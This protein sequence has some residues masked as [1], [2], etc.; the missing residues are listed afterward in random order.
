[1]AG[2]YSVSQVNAYIRNMFLQDFMLRRITVSGE[3]SNCKYHPSGHIYFTL[4][5]EQGTLSAVMF[6]SRRRNLTF[7]LENGQKVEASGSIQ[8][9]EAQGKYQLY[10]DVIRQA[11]VGDLYARFE[12]L[13]EKLEEMGMFAPE[14]KKPIPRFV[15]TVGIVTASTGAAIRDIINIATRRNPYVQL[16]LCPALVQGEG[17][18][19]SI[20]HAIR[21]L[22]AMGLDCIIAGRG[23]GSIE[24]LWA[25]N[26]EEVAQAIFHCQTPIISAVGH[27]TDFTIA[28]FVAD[29]RAPT[30]S[31]AAELAV[32]EA[33]RFFREL[34][35]KA[36]RLS[37]DMAGILW[38]RRSE[39]EQNRLK[40]MAYSPKNR[41]NVLRSEAAMREKRLDSAMI[42]IL[43]AK[44]HALALSA[45]RLDAM[46]PLAHFRGGYAFAARA[47]GK[48]IHSV[49]EVEAGSMV[50]VF[51]EDGSFRSR[52]EEINER[53]R[54]GEP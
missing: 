46:S 15:R 25:F 49:S 19:A 12:A 32:F 20:A 53:S 51:L 27:E 28:D 22:D 21:R 23:G 14:Y 7:Q 38:D 40:L 34:S 8:I 24:D 39:V 6:Q 4:K 13:K 44:K 41:L 11:G 18:A 29:L 35:E 31:A 50:D 9:Y 43:E 16:I 37:D 17:A 42:R 54:N 48:P 30:P 10:A 36:Q 33:D 3:V 5:D 52:V 45:R 26:E 47:D 2:V 1:M